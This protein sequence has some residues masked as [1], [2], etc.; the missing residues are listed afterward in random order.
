MLLFGF[1]NFFLLKPHVKTGLGHFEGQQT[2]LHSIY[3]Y[4]TPI[5]E[6]CDKEAVML[7][8][9]KHFWKCLVHLRTN[10]LFFF[11]C[12]EFATIILFW[13]DSQIHN[14]RS[15][16]LD[17]FSFLWLIGMIFKNTD[18]QCP[19]GDKILFTTKNNITLIE[20]L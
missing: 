17:C 7:Q 2:P 4:H 18:G 8:L 20:L 19:H 16:G 6:N 9:S 15:L 5:L 1:L 12:T 3:A 13:S 11:S 10:S 14:A